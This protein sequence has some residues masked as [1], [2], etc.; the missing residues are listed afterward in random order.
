M[1]TS[2]LVFFSLARKIGLFYPTLKEPL[3]M[4]IGIGEHDVAS[5][6]EPM[7][8]P[9]FRFGVVRRGRC[10]GDHCWKW[11]RVL[12]LRNQQ[13]M[14]LKEVFLHGK[15][16]MNASVALSLLSV[17]DDDIANVAEPFLVFFRR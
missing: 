2:F 9:F 14:W 11:T 10:P 5:L 4:G 8:P 6:G 17:M 13:K 3:P 12:V 15:T 16:E 1:R 7:A